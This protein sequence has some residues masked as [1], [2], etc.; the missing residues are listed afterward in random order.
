[1][2]DSLKSFRTV[3]KDSRQSEN[4]TDSLESFRTVCKVSG[5][6]KK[7]RGESGKF[8]DSRESCWTIWKVSNWSGQSRNFRTV[9]KVPKG[10]WTFPDSLESFFLQ[11]GF[12]KMRCT[13][14]LVAITM[15]SVLA[16]MLQKQFTHFSH[17]YMSRKRFTHFV[18]RVFARKSVL[19]G[20][21][22]LFRPLLHALCQ[23]NLGANKPLSLAMIS[24][25]LSHPLVIQGGLYPRKW[26]LN[27]KID[28]YPMKW[29]T[30]T[31]PKKKERDL[32][33]F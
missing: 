3:W 14:Q 5:G 20:K 4:M 15:C 22:R 31:H 19:T 11:F 10:S 33:Y 18:R 29:I 12:K 26:S 7:F 2:P 8:P 23:P 16:F 28:E 9:W 27:T 1:M 30:P 17:I 21:L 6:S 25:C 32:Q 24:T 13:C